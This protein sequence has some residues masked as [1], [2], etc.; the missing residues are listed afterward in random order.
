MGLGLGLGIWW[1]IQTSIIP[2]IL[3]PL[4]ARATYF[5]NV[6]CTTA[7]LQK[8]ENI[9]YTAPALPVGL[10]ASYPGA[11][12]AYS[13][14]NLI[15][16]TTNVVRV[17]R[18]TD[19]AEQNFTATQITDGTLVTFTG[20]NDGFVTTWY[21][22]SGNSNNAAQA[23]AANQPKLVSSGVVELDNQEPC[24]VWDNAND[25][26]TIN[27]SYNSSNLLSIFSVY[28]KTTPIGGG[29]TAYL[30]IADNSISVPDGVL[31]WRD[32]NKIGTYRSGGFSVGSILYNL[33]VTSS[34]IYTLSQVD[35]YNNNLLVGSTTN[36]NAISNFD[37]TSIQIG[38][39]AGGSAFKNQELIIYPSDQSA[40]RNDIETNINTNYG[41]FPETGLLADYPNASVAY[42]LRNLSNI[43]RNV[44]RVRRS[45]DNTEQNFTSTEITDGTLTTFTGTNDGFVTIWYDQSGYSND[46]TQSTASKQPK[47]VT[48]GV[49]ELDNGKPCLRYDTTG[50]DS[51]N[52]ATRL[53]DAR[54]TFSVVNFVYNSGDFTQYLFGDSSVYYYVSGYGTLLSSQ[55]AASFVKLGDNKVNNISSDFTT[56]ARPL[57]QSL[58]S[59]IHTSSAGRISRISEDRNYNQS[60]SLQGKLQEI[61]IY[62]TDQ[63]SNRTGIE[64][65]INNEYTIY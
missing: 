17:R 54:S 13:L 12:A 59:M 28:N 25:T 26:M 50:N 29:D 35:F 45:S 3:R 55:Y 44:V 22:Q 58:V 37:Y 63:S 62:P 34:F 23:T 20:A 5:E 64:T 21:D 8:I 30:V 51:F 6:R 61:I 24:I 36:S 27:T 15:D 49:V 48:N 9:P 2:G 60:R 38:R 41:I 65:N 10:L 11:S 7:T 19:N 1:P 4:K 53:T 47:L 56:T 31:A 52:L 33:Q 40:N 16:T 39:T 57:V 32:T 14:R 43:T 42:S 46:A 18:S